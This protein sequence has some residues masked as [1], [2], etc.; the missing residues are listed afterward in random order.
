[1]L[2]KIQ[3]NFFWEVRRLNLHGKRVLLFLTLLL[4]TMFTITGQNEMFLKKEFIY[5]TDTLGYRILYPENYDAKKSYPLVI[6][7][8][9]SGERGT[10]NEKQ[11]THGAIL[12]IKRENRTQYP[13]IVIFPQCPDKQNWAP[14]KSREKG[15]D[16]PLKSTST[17]PMQLLMRLIAEIKKN[18]AVDKKRIYVAGLSMGGMGTLDLICRQPKTFAAAIPICGGVSIERLKKLKNM[19]IRIYHGGADLIISPE[20]SKNVYNKLKSLGSNNVELVIFPEVGHN[21]WTK[22]FASPDF[23]SWMYAQH[24]K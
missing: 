12:F 11:L 13:S 23:L 19:P 9:G 8:H 21:S 4:S 15:F 5:K 3:I 2:F 17:E 1:M 22:A 7:L 6:F 24:L 14:I 16:Y 20:H 18:E 10:D